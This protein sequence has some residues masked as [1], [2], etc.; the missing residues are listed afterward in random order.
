MDIAAMISILFMVLN[1]IGEEE[2][3]QVFDQL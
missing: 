3:D 1:F 2:K